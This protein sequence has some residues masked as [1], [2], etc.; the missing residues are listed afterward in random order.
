MGVSST[1]GFLTWYAQSQIICK[2]FTLLPS[3]MNVPLQPSSHTHLPR[4]LCIIIGQTQTYLQTRHSCETTSSTGDTLIKR[5]TGAMW[6]VL[7]GRDRQVVVHN[8][9]VTLAPNCHRIPT[10]NELVADSDQ[11]SD[12]EVSLAECTHETG[13]VPYLLL[14]TCLTKG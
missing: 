1:L 3:S 2:S 5:Q 10:Y 13:T 9:A 4:R 7:R 6:E 8:L 11:P 12:S 14:F